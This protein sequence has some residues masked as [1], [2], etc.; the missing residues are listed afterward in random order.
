MLLLEAG[1]T[2]RR[3]DVIV[4]G[5]ASRLHR[6]SADWG[7]YTTPQRGLGGRR[8]YVPR[9]K[10]LGGSGSTNTLIA[11]RGV[12]LDYDEWAAMGAEGWAWEDV[13]PVFERIDRRMPTERPK[14]LHPLV[15]RYL[16]AGAELGLRSIGTGSRGPSSP[17]SACSV[18][19]CAAAGG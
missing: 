14:D 10:V 18:S 5:A 19:T 3:P 11:I 13:R 15:E 8:V 6:S 17:G 16:A 4:P 12:P 7:F 1:G 9:G 2:D